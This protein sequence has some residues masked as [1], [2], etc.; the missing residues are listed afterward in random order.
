MRGGVAVCITGE[1]GDRGQMMR[2]DREKEM[3]R[4]GEVDH[5]LRK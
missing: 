3:E 4:V 2:R 5:C 1:R